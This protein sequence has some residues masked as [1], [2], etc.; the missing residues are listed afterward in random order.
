MRVHVGS[1]PV[2]LSGW[3]N[4]DIVPYSGVHVVCDVRDGLPFA[5]VEAMFAEH[6]IEHLTLA[7][8]LR[9][10]R[11]SRRVL[12][13]DGVLR[14]STP[15]LDWVWLTHYK[16]PTE[17]TADE[18]LYGCLELNRAFHGWGHEFLYN[19]RT[20]RRALHSAG[21]AKVIE[22]VYGE[23]DLAALCSLERHERHRDL[24]GAPSVLIVEA[25]GSG[26]SDDDFER[27][28]VPYLR[29]AAIS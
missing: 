11:E 1:G 20:L 10:L 14:L 23:S 28:L 26:T 8:G 22:R 13:P 15:N 5:R 12:A 3:I 25:S 19:R 29:D 2:S 27:L 16:P 24:P 9:F 6:F 7:D 4:V 21:F 17:M 18:E